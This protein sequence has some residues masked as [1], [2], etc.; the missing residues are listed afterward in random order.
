MFR[1]VI[2]AACLSL[3]GM[4]GAT[5]FAGDVIVNEQG[6]KAQSPEIAVGP[7]GSV[8]MVWI[9]ENT[10]AA[11]H[12]HSKYGHSH[13]AATNLLYARSS[14]GGATFGKPVQ[15]NANPG[16]VWG[17]SVSKPRIA[18]GANGT[19]HVFYPAN[20]QSPYNGKPV[21]VAHYTRSTD[22][23]RS[24]DKPTRVHRMASTDASDFVHGGLTH[25]HVF[26]TLAVGDEGTV[27]TLWID[28]RD[29]AQEGDAG[30]VFMAVS[31]DDGRSF[32][33]DREIL[34]A[35]VCPCCQLTAFVDAKG[36]LY[37]GS[38]LVDG[39]FRDSAVMS[40]TDGGR[41]FSPRTSI[42][43]ARWEIEGC[44]LKPTAVVAANDEVVAAYFS[45]GESPQGAYLVRSD[46]GGTSW[47]KPM[48]LHPGA[49]ISDA[50]V[51]AL[52]GNTLHVFWHAKVGNGPRRI[53]T[54]ASQD[55]GRSFGQVS[56]LP[57]QAGVAAQLPVIAPHRDGSVQLAWQQGSEV[58]SMRWEAATPVLASR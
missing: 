25:A 7:D 41:S 14:D 45:G 2:S 19:I 16:E 49:S 48:L 5:A 23:G 29:M 13:L 22:G 55:L 54:R 31:R 39:K 12:D 9:D 3:A 43:G 35:N 8:H 18:V 53:F 11:A 20:D 56:E 34:P 32:E 26:G 42:V 15:I 17:F 1:L 37:V 21:A 40:S 58:R 36:K 33:T 6:H 44:P 46:D 4:I 10:A 30:K 57:V 24:F 28:T 27:Y 38:R 47:S 50:P 52:A 51:L